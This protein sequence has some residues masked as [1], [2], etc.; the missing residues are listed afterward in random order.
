[1]LPLPAHCRS[2]AQRAQDVSISKQAMRSTFE[3]RQP[4]CP[5]VLFRGRG[6]AGLGHDTSASPWLPNIQAVPDTF[7]C[8]TASH[9]NLDN[10]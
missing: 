6:M 8:C 4:G 3:F 9:Q 5:Q 7:A 2:A 10:Q 1:M